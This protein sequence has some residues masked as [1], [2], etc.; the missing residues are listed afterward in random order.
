MTPEEAVRKFFDCYTNGARHDYDNA[1]PRR[2]AT[3]PRRNREY[4]E[5]RWLP[6][7]LLR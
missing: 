2:S 1:G 3:C 5:E 7:G 4:C 6:S